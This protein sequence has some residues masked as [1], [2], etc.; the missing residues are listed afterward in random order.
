MT[1]VGIVC[2]YNPL[3]PGHIEQI[4]QIRDR[5]PDA[6]IVALMSG[7]FVQRGEVAIWPKTVRARAALHSGVNLVLELPFP[8]SSA[9]APGFSG[10]GV[11]ILRRLS[12]V[13]VLAFGSESGD[14]D[15]LISAAKRLTDPAFERELSKT[16]RE[17]GGRIPY[18]VCRTA[19]YFRL[20]G[21]NLPD[22]PNDIL[23]LEYLCAL[24]RQNCPIEPLIL[25]RRSPHSASAARA[26]L[27]SGDP[28]PPI[29]PTMAK[30]AAGI[31][32]VRP[33]ILTLPILTLLST[34]TADELA[35]YAEMTPD[36]A[37]SLIRAA[38]SA[39][40][41]PEL[42]DRVGG[43]TYPDARVR[44]ALLFALFRATPERLAAPVQTVNLL[45]ADAQGRRLLRRSAESGDLP[46]VT[47]RPP[48]N[49]AAGRDFS[50]RADRLYALAAG[51]KL[52]FYKEKP[53]LI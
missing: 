28:D 19:A 45:A 27:L 35:G 48:E 4:G 14:P 10:A 11:E 17:A 15:A 9:S 6:A 49:L 18:A 33:D 40:S 41:L 44:R 2:E 3:H 12:V 34:A 52:D 36:L 39:K 1:V 42:L 23:G 47:T 20:Y 43:K 46:T 5:F 22:R 13:D 50:D 25:P 31:T 32:P 24:I 51:L 8:Y 7:N 37:H 26:A 53:E 29:A 38:K 30:A 16:V 21:Q